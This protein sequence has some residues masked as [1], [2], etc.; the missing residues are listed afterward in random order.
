[1]GYKKRTAKFNP[2][3]MAQDE[4]VETIMRIAEEHGIELVMI[5]DSDFAEA[6]ALAEASAGKKPKKK[7]TVGLYEDYKGFLMSRL[8]G[9]Y[10]KSSN[11]FM[12]DITSSK[13]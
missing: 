10:W 1:M 5:T 9:C 3:N 7:M 11:A 12:D 4:A 8:N 13:R 2:V 6:Y